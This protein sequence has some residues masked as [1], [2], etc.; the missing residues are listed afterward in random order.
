MDVLLFNV[1][2]GGKDLCIGMAGANESDNRSDGDA[3]APKAWFAPHYIGVA[4]D[5][6]KIWHTRDSIVDWWPPVVPS[7]KEL[8]C[9]PPSRGREKS[10]KTGGCSGATTA[11]MAI[12]GT[13]WEMCSL[14]GSPITSRWRDG[15]TKK[16][17]L[18]RQEDEQN[19]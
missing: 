10:R 17:A 6:V 19:G 3:H 4:S 14:F 15:F 12:T 18:W 1:R 11:V 7:A 16:C 9:A 5:T 8:A 13:S 2:I